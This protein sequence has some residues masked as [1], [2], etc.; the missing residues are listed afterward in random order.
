MCGSGCVCVGWCVWVSVG[1]VR[2]CVGEREGVWV[3]LC[4]DGCVWG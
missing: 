4:V 1:C 2:V 3:G